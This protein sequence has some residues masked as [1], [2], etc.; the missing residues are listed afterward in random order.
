MGQLAIVPRGEKGLM[1]GD[2][3]LVIGEPAPIGSLNETYG[4]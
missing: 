2:R 3:L 1:P 4:R